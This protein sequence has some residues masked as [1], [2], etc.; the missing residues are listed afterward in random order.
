MPDRCI[1]IWLVRMEGILI[2]VVCP[3]YNAERYARQCLNSLSNQ[4]LERIEFICIDDGSTDSSYDILCEYAEKDHR[5]RVIRQSNAGY[6]YTMNK[7][8]RLAKGKYVGFLDPD[9]FIDDEAYRSL[10]NAAAQNGFPDIVKA[11]FYRHSSTGDSFVENYAKDIC[12]KR[13]TVHDELGKRAL[14]STPSIWSALY[15][16]DFIREWDLRLTETPGV[17]YQ[18]T[19]FVFKT[20][21]AAS[22]CYLIHDAYVHYRVDNP[23]SSSVASGNV[24]RV[25]EEYD[26]I[27]EFLRQH[28]CFAEF[29]SYAAVM[30]FKTYV[31]NARR[32]RGIEREQFVSSTY[33]EIATLRND[34]CLDSKLLPPALM[35]LVD[36]Y[37]KREQE[38]SENAM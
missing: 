21:I 2:S 30:R 13:L 37:A 34:G 15:R 1:E 35:K 32:L 33:Q 25:K 22:S 9:D 27:D 10:Y 18:D 12:G 29:A 28:D 20:W 11:N 26:F 7:G 16:R 14:L 4:M 24:F 23:N 31:W 17:S 5:F 19:A 36:N 38:F 3:V 6:G 8:I